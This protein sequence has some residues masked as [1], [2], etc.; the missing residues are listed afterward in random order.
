MLSDPRWQRRFPKCMRSYQWDADF[1][2]C[3]LPCHGSGGAGYLWLWRVLFCYS[4]I[5]LGNVMVSLEADRKI[6]MSLILSLTVLPTISG[7]LIRSFPH[8]SCQKTKR[9][10]EMM[11]KH[12]NIC[13]PSCQAVLV[14]PGKELI[15]FLAASIVLCLGFRMRITLFFLFCPIKLP[16]SP[17]TFS[18][19][20]L[21][22]LSLSHWSGCTEQAAVLFSCWLGWNCDMGVQTST[23]QWVSAPG[24][25]S[26]AIL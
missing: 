15:F 10:V 12:K 17:P 11:R 24:E 26:S 18:H 25:G 22:V 20:A 2:Q 13:E 7:L 4:N 1:C 16:L 8:S 23:Q 21:L 19:F 5:L 9:S 14:S 3:L 6:L